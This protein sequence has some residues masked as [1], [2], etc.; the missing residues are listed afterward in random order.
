MMLV[1]RVAVFLLILWLP[2]QGIA[3]V[4]MPF[5]AHATGQESASSGPQADQNHHAHAHSPATDSHAGH[6]PAPTKHSDFSC[7]GCGVCH[8]ACAPTVPAGT[9]LAFASADSIYSQLCS[10]LV[11]L[12]IPEQPQPPPNP[13]V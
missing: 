6:D 10:T 3:A 2:L 7:N 11:R 1:R 5:C 4:A 12:F 9:I 13:S 8:L